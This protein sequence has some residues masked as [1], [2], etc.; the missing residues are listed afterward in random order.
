M[1]FKLNTNKKSEVLL[2]KKK[3]I[4]TMPITS[5]CT[6]VVPIT[7][8]PIAPRRRLHLM[9]AIVRAF[10]AWEKSNWLLTCLRVTGR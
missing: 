8:L 7:L 2:P 3:R 6:V 10:S 9:V 1:Q 5:A 4:A